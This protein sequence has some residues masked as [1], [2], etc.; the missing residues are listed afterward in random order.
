MCRYL[1]TQIFFKKIFLRGAP[2][3][4]HMWDEAGFFVGSDGGG[5]MV[6]DIEAEFGDAAGFGP[7]VEV[8]YNEGIDAFAAVCEVDVHEA[9]IGVEGVDVIRFGGF[10]AGV[11]G[12]EEGV[13]LFGDREFD[14]GAGDHGGDIVIMQRIGFEGGVEGAF[15]GDDALFKAIEGIEVGG[16]CG[17]DFNVFHTIANIRTTGVSK[18]NNYCVWEA[19]KSLRAN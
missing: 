3:V 10:D 6:V 19:D 4:E 7:L 5:I 11:A 13:V 2:H 16:G 18:A 12:A 15:G 9:E 14:I 1:A 17:S 8:F